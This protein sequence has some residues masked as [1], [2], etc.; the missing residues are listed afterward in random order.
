MTEKQLDLLVCKVLVQRGLARELLHE[1][2]FLGFL[3]EI[4]EVLVPPLIFLDL[5]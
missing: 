1:V 2:A 4:Q 3:K 5:R